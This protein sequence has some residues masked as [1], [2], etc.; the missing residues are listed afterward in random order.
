MDERESIIIR[1]IR[2]FAENGSY[3]PQIEESARGWAYSF[4]E[5]AGNRINLPKSDLI[6]Y[7]ERQL[8]IFKNGS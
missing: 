4:I 6:E 3:C 8:E 7:F 2:Q 1:T 5:G